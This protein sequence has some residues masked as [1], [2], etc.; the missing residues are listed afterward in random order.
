M[1]ATDTCSFA[2][3]L[4][5]EVEMSY[6]YLFNNMFALYIWNDLVNGMIFFSYLKE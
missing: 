3:F 4:S 1:I 5:S 6:S 2:Q